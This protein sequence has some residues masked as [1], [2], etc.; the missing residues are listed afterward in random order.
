KRS[1]GTEP[2]SRHHPVFMTESITGMEL[3]HIPKGCFQMGSP[4][5]NKERNFDEGPL[6]R[7]CVEEFWLGKYEVNQKLW[8]KIKGDNPA[9][10]KKGKDYPVEQISWHDVQDFISRLN[11]MTSRKFRLPFEAEWE[12][13]ARAGTATSRYWGQEI[14]CDKAMYENNANWHSN[15]C[16]DALLAQGLTLDSTAP[17]GSYPANPFGLHDMLGNVREWCEDWFLPD[18]YVSSPQDNPK[19]PSSGSVR[20]IRGGGWVDSSRYLR[21]AARSGIAPEKRDFNLGFR[22]VLPVQ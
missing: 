3:A 20:V 18:Y 8:Q 5:E 10:F 13:A 14:S 22:L 7:V 2:A 1:S 9:L 11:K 19:G 21:A 16:A 15:G 12:Y 17:V 4:A 6:H